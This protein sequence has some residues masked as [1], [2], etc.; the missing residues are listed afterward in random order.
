MPT[1]DRGCSDHFIKL[2]K[3]NRMAYRVVELGKSFGFRA[4]D[5]VD[6]SSF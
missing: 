5:A 3:E 4:F 6:K 1:K 2:M